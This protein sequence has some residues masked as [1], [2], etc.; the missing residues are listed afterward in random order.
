MWSISRNFPW[1]WVNKSLVKPKGSVTKHHGRLASYSE[2]PAFFSSY[3]PFIPLSCL[4]LHTGSVWVWR[5]PHPCC[6]QAGDGKMRD[7]LGLEEKASPCVT[8]RS[9]MLVS[10]SVANLSVLVSFFEIKSYYVIW[11]GL[12]L[13]IPLPPM[14]EFWDCKC[15][16]LC[17]DF[18][19]HVFEFISLC[20]TDWTIS[21]FPRC[22]LLFPLSVSV[23]FSI[24]KNLKDTGGISAIRF[25]HSICLLE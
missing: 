23:W 7:I 25:L 6:C 20:F 11:D 19:K 17:P 3:L 8:S 16:P 1:P 13:T 15:V 12:K 18:F 4:C 22:V 2:L 24:C 9:R 10:F 5:K 14:L 21:L